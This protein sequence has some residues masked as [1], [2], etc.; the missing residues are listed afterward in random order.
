MTTAP[1]RQK[2]A[3]SELVTAIAVLAI[4]GG[5]GA[6][7][8]WWSLRRQ[9]EFQAQAVTED[10]VQSIADSYLATPFDLALHLKQYQ[11]VRDSE[12]LAESPDQRQ[13]FAL[14]SERTAMGLNRMAQIYGAAI[15]S[16]DG[17]EPFLRK[18]IANQE[19][20]LAKVIAKQG[21]SIPAGNPAH[22]NMMADLWE[23]EIWY[24]VLSAVQTNQTVSPVPTSIE[25]L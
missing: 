24:R 7:W 1:L 11:T 23:L 4:V 22:R 3:G 9:Q 20:G 5:I 13:L 17:A 6:G 21:A 2:Y 8:G 25:S 16:P 10:T 15:V 14:G 12:T 19:A 18:N